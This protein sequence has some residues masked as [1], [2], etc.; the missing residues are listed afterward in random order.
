VL[1]L[2][3]SGREIFKHK[4][5]SKFAAKPGKQKPS[6]FPH[7]KLPHPGRIHGT[8]YIHVHEMVDF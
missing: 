2:L 7:G 3:V 6:G 5:S 1:L 8:W 4:K